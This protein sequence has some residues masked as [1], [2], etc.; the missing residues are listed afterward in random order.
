MKK[1]KIFQNASVLSVVMTVALVFLA[2]VLIYSA[3]S[4]FAAGLWFSGC[5]SILGVLLVAVACWLLLMGQK[6]END[7]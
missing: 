7:K 5:V 6:K 2:G 4:Q 1:P 3:V